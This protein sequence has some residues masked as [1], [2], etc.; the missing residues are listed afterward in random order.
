MTEKFIIHV[1]ISFIRLI[2]MFTKKWKTSERIYDVIRERSV[3]IKV[4]DGISLDCDIFRPNTEGKFP[5]ILSAHPYDKYGQTEPIQV[6]GY[7]NV[8]K[9]I[10]ERRRGTLE[11]GDPNFFVRR[12]YVHVILNVRGTGDSEGYYEF[13]GPRE[14]QDIYEVIERLAEFPWSNGNIGT[15]GVSYFAMIA[16]AVAAKNPPHL[17]CIFAPWGSTDPYRDMFYQGGILAGKYVVDFAK[18]LQ[19][20]NTRVNKEF[21]RDELEKID[22]LLKDPDITALPELREALLNPEKDLNPFIVKILIHQLYDD[23]WRERTVDLEKIRIPSYLGGDWANYGFHL[24]AAFRAWDKIR[25]PKKLTIGPPY[26]L[27][28]PVYQL[29]YEALRWFDYWL[30]GIDTGINEEKPIKIFVMGSNK[31]RESEEWPLPETKWV[32]FYLHERGIL[33]EHEFWDNESSD[34]YFDS[35]WARGYAKYVT[36]KFVEETEIVG[37]PILELFLSTTDN[38][39]LLSI[40]LLEIDEKGNERVLTGA[41]L[42]GS[43]K[44][45]DEKQSTPWSFYYKHENREQL[46]PNKI[47]KFKIEI[48]PTANLFRPGNRLGLLISSSDPPS[49]PYEAGPTS[50][51]IKRQRPSRITLY[52]DKDHPSALWVPIISGN[53]IGTYLSMF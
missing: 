48:V 45:I 40:R 23:F 34:S 3:K 6:G 7:S 15:F 30:K 49:S 17:K 18:F 38:E 10:E 9:A 24:P 20:S 39:V 1:L 36:P 53:I 19:E 12:G 33:S 11:A 51:H 27:D 5:V 43:Q 32:P 2:N 16:L 4:S 28:R 50:R 8:E 25:A 26:F 29:Q 52:H 37:P 21:S 22:A 46:E 47:Y 31:W 41:W 42:R 14:V 44:Q 35:P 13:L